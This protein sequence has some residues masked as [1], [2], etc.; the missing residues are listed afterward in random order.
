MNAQVAPPGGGN[1][2]RW[3]KVAPGT[4]LERFPDFMIVGPQRTGTSWLYVKLR[5]HPGI[6][7]SRPK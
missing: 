7:L 5:F 3:V 4:S 6:Q 2:L 1:T